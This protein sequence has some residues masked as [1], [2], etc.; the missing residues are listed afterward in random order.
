MIREI[1]AHAIQSDDSRG[2][3]EVTEWTGNR[4]F[5]TPIAWNRYHIFTG[6]KKVI[7]VFSDDWQ[8]TYNEAK[9]IAI[10][11]HKGIRD[12]WTYPLNSDKPLWRKVTW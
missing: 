5:L 2:G 7:T 11:I 4:C 9:V 10:E 1:Y 8:L 6:Q 12:Y 3:W